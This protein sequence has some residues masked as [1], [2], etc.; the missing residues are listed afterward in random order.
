[1]HIASVCWRMRAEIRLGE[2]DLDHLALAHLADSA[3]SQGGEG[4][5]DRFA[6]RIENARLSVS[7]VR[8]LSCLRTPIRPSAREI[9]G[10]YESG[11]TSRHGVGC[12]S[13]SA[14]RN[15]GRRSDPSHAGSAISALDTVP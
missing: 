7:P 2:I 4:I 13:H 1:L 3:E 11:I 5:A 9:C 6:L 15:T 10:G 12:G 8:A 14:N